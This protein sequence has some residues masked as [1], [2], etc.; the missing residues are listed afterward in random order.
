[1]AICERIAHDI[2]N[3]YTIGYVSNS[4]ARADAYRTIRVA[5]K[6]AEYGKLIVRVRA[7]YIAGG[8]PPPVKGKTAK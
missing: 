3:Q 1:M 5:A 8:E 2:R 4:A 7:G 6:A